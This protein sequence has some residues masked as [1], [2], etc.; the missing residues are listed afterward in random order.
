LKRQAF[1]KY[2][3]DVSNVKSLALLTNLQIMYLYYVKSQAFA[4]RHEFFQKNYCAT[5]KSDNIAKLVETLEVMALYPP[6]W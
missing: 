4:K 5:S 1:R 2:L 3:G 6:L